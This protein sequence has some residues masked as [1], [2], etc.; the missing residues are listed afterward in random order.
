[1]ASYGMH[2]AK[3]NLSKLV[4]QA[5]AGEEVVITRNG[6]PAVRMVRVAPR[7]RFQNALGAW[8]DRDDFWIADDF[9]TG[10]SSLTRLREMPVTVLKI[11][12]SFLRLV[13]DDPQAAA[14]VT[15][16][17][18]LGEALGMIAVA[19]GVE[20]RGQQAFLV[21]H[22]CPLAQGFLLGRP[23]PAES[24]D[25]LPVPTYDLEVVSARG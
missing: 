3:T 1:M 5:E 16:V 9:G 21:E 2:E 17:L 15:A 12:R 19:E 24:L 25:E 6:A 14:M 23:V 7:K 22:G 11:D 8:A 4:A 18:G 13:P 20:T 10:H